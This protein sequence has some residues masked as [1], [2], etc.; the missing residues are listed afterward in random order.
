MGQSTRPGSFS[1]RLQQSKFEQRSSQPKPLRIRLGIDFGTRF[2]KVCWHDGQKVEVVP[3][4]LSQSTLNK[5]LLHSAVA[6]KSHGELF[7]GQNGPEWSSREASDKSAKIFR[8]LKMKLAKPSQYSENERKTEAE[9][10]ADEEVRLMSAWLLSRVIHRAKYWISKCREARIRNRSLHWTIC[11]GVPVEYSDS[12]ARTVF[13]KV[14]NLAVKLAEHPSLQVTSDGRVVL[15]S[16]LE[17]LRTLARSLEPHPLPEQHHIEVF[18]EIAAAIQS[19]T[20]SSAARDGNYLF[21]DVGGGTVDGVAFNFERKGADDSPRLHFYCGL[22]KPLGVSLLAERLKDPS[23]L[24]VKTL[25]T[26]LV[27]EGR[28]SNGLVGL[29]PI[30]SALE[31]RLKRYQRDL[32][33]QVCGIMNGLK[34][35]DPL[36]FRPAERHHLPEAGKRTLASRLAKRPE[37]P[38]F[39]GGGGHRSWFYQESFKKAHSGGPNELSYVPSIQTELPVPDNFSMNGLQ[40]DHFHRFA[41]AYGLALPDGVRTHIG[42]PSQAKNGSAPERSN[43]NAEVFVSKDQV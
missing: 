2:I 30:N 38:L 33:R 23:K 41:V 34:A 17:E 22:V 3:F 37:I 15:S 1:E 24:P 12:P 14:L 18:E 36:H 26:W 6:L 9:S 29:M 39:V 4:T 5:T 7:A 13:E 10:K 8:Y 21:F 16:S 32:G 11:I 43:R 27:T 31:E 28:S 20:H 40:P 19:F 42:L 35:V 25:E